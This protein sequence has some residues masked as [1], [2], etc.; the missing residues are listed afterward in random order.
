MRFGKVMYF[1]HLYPVDGKNFEF[2]K[3]K[4][5]DSPLSIIVFTAEIYCGM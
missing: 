3:Y 4:M 1:G 2:L 5:A